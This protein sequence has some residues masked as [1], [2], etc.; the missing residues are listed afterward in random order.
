VEL[1]YELQQVAGKIFS[2]LELRIENP[3][4]CRKERGKNG[5]PGWLLAHV[6]SIWE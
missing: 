3:H 4:F 1:I 5:A 6:A 2:P